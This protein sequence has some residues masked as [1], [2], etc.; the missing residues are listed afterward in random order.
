MEY[1]VNELI[2]RLPSGWLENYV[3]AFEGG[4]VQKHPHARFVTASGESCL[5]G[6]L[7]GARTSA[8]VVAS[9]VWSRFLGTELEDLSRHFE[10]RRLTAQEVYEEVLLALATRKP[11]AR[12]SAP[13]LEMACA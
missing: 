3:S 12:P 8:E 6:A 7:A 2:E 5:V 11:E 1:R 10:A 4:R 13:A 9:P